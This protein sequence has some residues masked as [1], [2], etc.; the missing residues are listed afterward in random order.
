MFYNFLTIALIFLQSL[1]ILPNN[2]GKILPLR[3]TG[4][5]NIAVQHSLKKA[6]RI[7]EHIQPKNAILPKG[8]YQPIGTDLFRPMAAQLKDQSQ[9]RVFGQSVPRTRNRGTHETDHALLLSNSQ[10]SNTRDIFSTPDPI[11]SN[12]NFHPTDSL[13]QIFGSKD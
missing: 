9:L 5:H 7:L 1:L 10:A 12:R 11:C 4:I 3:Q 8:L 6:G 13:I 2:L